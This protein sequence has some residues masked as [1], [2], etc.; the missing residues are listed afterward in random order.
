MIH[1]GTFT[2]K[3][4]QWERYLFP[5]KKSLVIHVSDPLQWI[6]AEP[7]VRALN[8]SVVALFRFDV[9]RTDVPNRQGIAALTAC[10]TA[11]DEAGVDCRGVSPADKLAVCLELLQPEGLLLCG[12]GAA[13]Q[14]AARLARERGVRT[15]YLP[16]GCAPQENTL[17]EADYSLP[18]AE[19]GCLQPVSADDKRN[20]IGVC[21]RHGDRAGRSRQQLDLV[22]ELRTEFPASQIGVVQAEGALVATAD[23]LALQALPGVR[24][25]GAGAWPALISRGRIVVADDVSLLSQAA[26]AG[27]RPLLYADGAIDLWDCPLN[28]LQLPA[29]GDDAV[30]LAAERCNRLIPYAPA[31]AAGGKLQIGCGGNVLAGW[32]NTDLYAAGSDVRYLDAARPYPF[33]DETFSYVFSEHLFEHLPVASGRAML[34]ECYRILRPGGHIRIT[35][36][37]LDFLIRLYRH[38]DDD[39][40]RRYIEW[41]ISHFDGAV[42]ELYGEADVPPLF[43]LNNFI[44]EWGHRMVYNRD[45]MRQ[46]LEKAGFRHIRFARP[47]ESTLPAFRGVEH[48]GEHIPEWCNALES[49]TIEGTKP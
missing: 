3:K 43:V 44:R 16:Q 25:L 38:P 39:L 23:D 10:E 42:Q 30:R 45:V 27:C 15:L 37:D 20:I 1:A 22:R 31:E 35:Q 40:H 21:L 48:H 32:L 33:A 41:S 9:Q 7:L 8:R 11:V 17:P 24:L 19:V 14:E 4:A 49:M 47:G 26:L 29:R 34:S 12:C 13:E 18:W 5:L 46:L 2:Q 6:Y 36:P 28:G